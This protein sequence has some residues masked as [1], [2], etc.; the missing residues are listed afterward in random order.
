[1]SNVI[2]R[3]DFGFSGLV[4]RPSRN[5][6]LCL[7]RT[8]FENPIAT[9]S[10]AYTYGF[11]AAESVGGDLIAAPCALVTVTTRGGILPLRQSRLMPAKTRAVRNWVAIHLVIQA[12]RRCRTG[13]FH[14][15]QL[16]ASRVLNRQMVQA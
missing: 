4:A 2:F 6:T 1:M 3:L 15:L 16:Q 12:C 14:T 13:L 10:F 11:Y 7:L 8:A 9:F 5:P